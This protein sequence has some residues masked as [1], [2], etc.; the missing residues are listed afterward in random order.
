MAYLAI[1]GS[2][3]ANGV[4]RLHG[5]VSRQ[6]LS[7]SVPEL[8]GGRKSRSGTLPTESTCPPGIR[9]PADELWTGKLRKGP[10]AGERRRPWR[11]TFAGSPDASSCGSFG[12]RPASLLWS[13]LANECPWRWPRQ[14][15]RPEEVEAATHLFDPNT[16]TL[17]FARRFA[18]YKRPNLLL[19]D[20]AAAASFVDQICSA[21]CSSSSPARRIPRTRAGQAL[22]REWMHFIRRPEAQSARD[23]P[24]VITT[25]S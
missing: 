10:L 20:P 6:P 18:T 8:A 9:R 17:G 13:M 12:R 25:C 5:E 21:R 22:I 14:A 23:L 1:R 2:G 7:A 3:A 11:K 16:L 4:S 24:R 15:R 19:H